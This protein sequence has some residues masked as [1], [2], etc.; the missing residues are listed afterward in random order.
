MLYLKLHHGRHD[1]DQDMEETG[2]DGPEIGP[3]RSVGGTYTTHLMLSFV[4]G[5]DAVKFGVDPAFPAINY[6]GDML[7]H[8][9]PGDDV[10]AYYGDWT[11]Y[12]K[13]GE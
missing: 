11:V 8:Q 9:M 2:F 7:A 3:L 1:P 4:D 12:A 13:E 6:H 5:A 10:V